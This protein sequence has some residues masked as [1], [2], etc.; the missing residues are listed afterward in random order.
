MS[1]CKLIIAAMLLAFGASGYAQTYPTRAVR[2]IVP[3]PPGG[4]TD[5]LARAMGRSSPR[6][7]TSR[8]SSTIDRERAA[9]SGPSSA[10]VRRVTA[11]P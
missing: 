2:V 7:G 1:I 11:I 8:S 6:R 9:S 5:I 4:S 10:P 3:F